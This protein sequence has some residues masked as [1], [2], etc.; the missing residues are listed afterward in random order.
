MKPLKLV[1]ITTV[2]ISLDLLL[3][4]QLKFMKEQGFEVL[5]ASADGPEIP[6]FIKREG[7]AHKIFPLTRKI[8]PFIDMKAVVSLKNWLKDV[9]PDIVHTHTPKAGL[10]GMMAALWA[11]VPHR[12]HTVAGMPLME[13]TGAKRKILEAAERVTYACATNVYPNSFNLKSFIEENITVDSDKLKVIGRGS[14][15]GIDTDFFSSK[16]GIRKSAETLRKGLGIRETDIVFC[17]VGRIVKDKGINELVR[18]FAELKKEISNIHL[19]LVGPFE[20]DLDPVAPAT[21]DTIQTD[22]RI[23]S[24]GFQEDIRPYLAI[25]DVFT[26]PSYREGFPNV[27]LQAACMEL[28][29]IVSDINGCNE[30]VDHD[31]TGL[32]IPPKDGKSLF[33]AMH[34]LATDADRRER[35]GREARKSVVKNYSQNAIWT[36]LLEEYRSLLS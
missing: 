7:V 13:E 27:V 14:S 17:F 2:P 20:D 3:R 34:I 29:L 33:E 21:K 22:K 8:T 24:V 9:N 28:P 10:I 30:I 32:I 12:L 15:N 1:R 4:G 6:V 23:H 19:V 36:A 35:L 5:T 16:S 31:E 18:A 11:G 26:F 25:S